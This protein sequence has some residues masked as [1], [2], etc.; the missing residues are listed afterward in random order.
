M[1][2]PRSPR[3]LEF[4]AHG[5]KIGLKVYFRPRSRGVEGQG[6]AEGRT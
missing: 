3:R 2:H 1:P 5:Y 4:G 6:I